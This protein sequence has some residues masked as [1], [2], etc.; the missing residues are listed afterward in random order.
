MIKVVDFLVYLCPVS[1]GS[2]ESDIFG[3]SFVICGFEV[4]PEDRFVSE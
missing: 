4:S 1:S 3:A 2:S